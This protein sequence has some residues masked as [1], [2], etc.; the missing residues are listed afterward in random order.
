MTKPLLSERVLE[1]LYQHRLM[2]RSQL[3]AMHCPGLDPS[4]L[5]RTLADMARTGWL[6]RVRL[7]SRR[8][9]VWF[10]TQAGTEVVEQSR[11]GSWRRRH[12]VTPEAARG[13]LLAHSLA[14]N[15]VGLAFMDAARRHGDDCGYLGWRHEVAHRLADGG[16]SVIC[17]LLLHYVATGA[18][19]RGGDVMLWRFIEVDRAT[20]PQAVLVEKLQDYVA[21]H[22]SYADARGGRSAHPPR[23]V[24]R[25]SSFPALIVVYADA[26]QRT[27]L[28]RLHSVAEMCRRDPVVGESE[29]PIAFTTLEDLRRAGPFEPIFWLVSDPDAPVNVLMGASRPVPGAE[30]LEE[31]G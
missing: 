29:L 12:V 2:S 18:G 6:D 1:G 3:Q 22:R 31:V 23:W 25:Y 9:A 10:L 5:S 27:L 13:P 28:R 16:G 20:M 4:H 8:G 17:D 24:G 30:V 26:P 21:L 19:R 7:D 15:D 14:G 11:P